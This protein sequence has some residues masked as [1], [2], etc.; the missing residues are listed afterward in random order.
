MLDYVVNL[1]VLGL[2]VGEIFLFI[3]VVYDDLFY[4]VVEMGEVLVKFRD[5]YGLVNRVS[6]FIDMFV[7]VSVYYKEMLGIDGFKVVKGKR[8]GG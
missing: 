7:S 5:I 3:L 2:L 6:N 4:K 1:F 8:I